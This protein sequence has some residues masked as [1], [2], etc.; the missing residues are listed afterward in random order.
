MDEPDFDYQDEHIKLYEE[1]RDFCPPSNQFS[2]NEILEEMWQEFLKQNDEDETFLLGLKGIADLISECT[3][4]DWDCL[5]AF[6]RLATLGA[7]LQWNGMNLIKSLEYFL[8][9][10]RVLPVTRK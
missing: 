3:K 8:S 4:F 7:D 5:I 10:L 2:K 6:Y 1:M 9:L